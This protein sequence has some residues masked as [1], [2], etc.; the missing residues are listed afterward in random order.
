MRRLRALLT[1]SLLHVGSGPVAAQ[2]TGSPVPADDEAVAT[3]I[4]QHAVPLRTVRAGS[5]F[6]DLEPLRAVLHD[7]RVDG[8]GEATHGTSEFQQVKHRLLE[9]LV[10][11]M[12]FTAFAIE[13]AYS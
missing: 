10:T 1:L 6:T 3:W 7:V 8:L 5:G 11:Q 2:S 9:F 13:A 4:E 12:G